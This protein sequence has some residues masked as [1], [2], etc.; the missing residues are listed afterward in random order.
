MVIKNVCLVLQESRK[1]GRRVIIET[2][3]S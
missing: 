1:A 3:V 2:V